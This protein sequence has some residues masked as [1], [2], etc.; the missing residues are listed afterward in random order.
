M[1]VIDAY[2]SNDSFNRV[3]VP[4][5]GIPLTE[6]NKYEVN[7]T[8]GGWDCDSVTSLTDRKVVVFSRSGGYFPHPNYVGDA[9][10]LIGIEGLNF[11]G[12]GCIQTMVRNFVANESIRLNKSDDT[13]ENPAIEYGVDANVDPILVFY[14]ENGTG[15]FFDIKPAGLPTY[16]YRRY[17]YLCVFKYNVNDYYFGYVDGYQIGAGDPANY[18]SQLTI[19]VIK[20]VNDESFIGVPTPPGEKGFR[21]TSA[22]TRDDVPGTGGRGSSNKVDPDYA[23]DSISQPGAPDETKASAIGSGFIN[24][25][26]ITSANLTN[27]GKC[28][29]SSTF[30]TAFNNLFVNPIDAVIS[31][32][33]FPYTPSIGTSQPIRLLNHLCITSD[34]GINASGFPLTS[35]FRTIDFGTVHVP[36]NWGNFLDYSDTQI[37]LYLPFIGA[38]QLDTSECMNGDVNVQYTI[39]FFT[40]MCVANVH[41]AKYNMLPNGFILSTCE[42][43][44]S[45]QGNCAIQ[46]PLTA[47][48]YGSMVGSL[49]NASTQ[50]LTNPAS[51]AVSMVSDIVGGRMKPSVTTKG[52]VVAN[53]GFCSVLFP[54]I[55][56]TRPITAEPDSYQDVVGY[57]SYINTTLGQCEDLCVCDGIDL[58]SV[59]GATDSEIERIR[60]MCLEGVHV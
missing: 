2:D 59:S 13:I 56:I 1:Y 19:A 16:G 26:D 23:S 40:G 54:Y 42:A 8:Y 43:Q 53:A 52:S 3:V 39:D 11:T 7:H 25:Y 47:V 55:R 21:P 6:L 41:C 37:E 14:D 22:Y 50:S 48:D 30:L 17:S 38:V 57:P 15:E 34:L 32:N 10:E 29:Y 36:E 28:L 58:H 44:H 31:L 18:V 5:L 45:Y 12:T 46:I 20:Y 27:V 60:Q 4:V 24:A 9:L 35:Q 51:G 33:V 49:I